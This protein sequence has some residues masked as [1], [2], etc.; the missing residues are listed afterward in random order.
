MNAGIDAP[1][2]ANSKQ[3]RHWRMS[4]KTLGWCKRAPGVFCRSLDHQRSRRHRPVGLRKVDVHPFASTRMHEVVNPRARRGPSA[5]RQTNIL[6]DVDPVVPA[7]GGIVFPSQEPS[8]RCRSAG[9]R[10]IAGLRLYGMRADRSGAARGGLCCARPPLG[11]GQTPRPP[12]ASLRR[13][14]G[15]VGA[16]RSLASPRRSS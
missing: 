2:G 10:Y 9:E 4:S 3:A 1:P 11:R 6:A 12:G 8:P 14:A 5:R 13:P 7:P 16:S 15:S